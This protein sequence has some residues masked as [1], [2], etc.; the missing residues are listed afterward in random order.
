MKYR[1]DYF[2]KTD[3]T[4]KVVRKGEASNLSIVDRYNITRKV[5]STSSLVSC[6]TFFMSIILFTI[7]SAWKSNGF[8]SDNLTFVVLF[9]SCLVSLAVFCISFTVFCVADTFMT[10]IKRSCAFRKLVRTK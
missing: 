3:Y 7:I 5:R 4:K 2:E 1:C 6:F 9:V 10:R 8:S